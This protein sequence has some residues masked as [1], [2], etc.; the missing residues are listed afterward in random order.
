MGAKN[1]NF[2]PKFQVPQNGDLQFEI[3]YFW[4]K[5]VLQAKI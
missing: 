5:I 4:K 2:A 3:L 1:L